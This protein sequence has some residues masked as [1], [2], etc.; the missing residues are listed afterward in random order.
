M[1]I[2]IIEDDADIRNEL[3]HLLNKYGY[4]TLWSD[5]FENIIDA[6]LTADPDLVLLDINLPYQD[7]F[8]V[9]R[10]LYEKLAA[11][12][13]IL[14]SRDSDYDELLGLHFGADD[15]IT[16]PYHAQVLLARIQKA[17]T[18]VEGGARASFLNHKGL[19]LN[20]DSATAKYRD[21]TCTLTKNEFIIL[22][23]LMQ[24]SGHILPRDAI[25]DALWQNEVFIDDNAL[26]VNMVRLRKK[27][28]ELGLDEYVVTKRGM[29]Y[30]V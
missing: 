17:L 19:T 9:C 18:H 27:L 5:D 12:I 10:S 2:Y 13:I 26:N 21:K 16:K 15:Y 14:T 23:L 28:A 29:G 30:L 1:R 25:M 24:N 3:V 4:E 7:G 22:R 6:T 8:V 20:L 11:P